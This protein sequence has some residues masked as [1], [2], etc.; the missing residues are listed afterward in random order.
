MS[1]PGTGGELEFD[2]RFACYS[3]V[4]VQDGD[5]WGDA[6][7]CGWS[8]GMIT[9][10]GGYRVVPHSGT[11]PSREIPQRYPKN[12]PPPLQHLLSTLKPASHQ[13]RAS[14]S[15]PPSST[16]KGTNTVGTSWRLCM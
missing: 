2:A 4:S 13:T 7:M 10:V 1:I 16:A 6:I 8:I 15:N 9:D 3:R 14:P 5:A 12:P 11:R